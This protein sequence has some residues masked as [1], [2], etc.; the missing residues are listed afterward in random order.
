MPVALSGGQLTRT[1][2]CQTFPPRFAVVVW[3]VKLVSPDCAVPC[4][5][6]LT[7]WVTV[8]ADTVLQGFMIQSSCLVSS[9]LRMIAPCP[10]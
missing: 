2:T 10:R 8:P 9:L 6:A 7:V 1:V 5:L 4:P 3:T